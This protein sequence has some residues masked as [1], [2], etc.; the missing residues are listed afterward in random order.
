M[1]AKYIRWGGLAAIL[2]GAL[3]LIADGWGLAQE[4]LGTG[5]ERFSEQATTSAWTVV[6]VL[7]MSGGVLIL[8]GL[9]GI[10]ARQAEA[11]GIL[12]LIGFLA[13]FVSVALVVGVF[14]T[15]TFVAPSAAIEAP[16]FLDNEQPAGPLMV[17]FMLSFMSFPV[18]LAL[19]GLATFRARV[20]PRLAAAA[21]TLGALI[22][23]APLPGVT[24]L[25]DAA[26]IWVGYSLYSERRAEAASSRTVPPV[27]PAGT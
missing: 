1:T 10:Y 14:W 18:G 7:F 13:A 25:L 24:I 26:L 5:P 16:A 8:L 19:F 2:G 20:F 17:G 9:V 11:A 15:F 22:S 23:F 3:L 12:G 6:S 21:L 4:L 27:Q